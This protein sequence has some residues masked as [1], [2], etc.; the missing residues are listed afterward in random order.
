MIPNIADI[1]RNCILQNSKKTRRT[2]TMSKKYAVI[3]IVILTAALCTAGVFAAVNSTDSKDTPADNTC[4]KKTGFDENAGE[5]K[6]PGQKPNI[7]IPGWESVTIPANKTDVSVDFFNPKANKGNYH[8]TF[9]LRLADGESLYQ[10]GLVRAGE[11]IRKI[12]L[13]RGLPAGTYDSY[14]HIQP[15]TAD[16]ALMETNNA[17][18]GLK[19]IVV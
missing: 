15:Y 10:S 7:A 17:D 13:S 19:L 1:P 11:H 4:G 3:L 6:A 8:M 14:I 12:T 16:D 2:Q 18:M 5:Y 9:E